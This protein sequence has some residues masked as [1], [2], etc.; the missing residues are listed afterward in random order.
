MNKQRIRIPS[1]VWPILFFIGGIW[2][3]TYKVGSNPYMIVFLL[4]LFIFIYSILRHRFRLLQFLPYWVS[5]ILFLS[6]GWGISTIQQNSFDRYARQ[7]D[8]AQFA[9]G[10]IVEVKQ[11]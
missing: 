10:E 11:F 2:L 8:T 5:L 1:L 9:T 6:L 3:S 7:L 4:L